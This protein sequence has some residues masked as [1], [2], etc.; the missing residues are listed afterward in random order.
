VTVIP[1]S[2]D[3][4]SVEED[5]LKEVITSYL[6]IDDVLQAH[7]LSTVVFTGP[8]NI[9]I[10]AGANK[11]L[12]SVGT[13]KIDVIDA[14]KSALFPPQEPYLPLTNVSSRYRV[15]TSHRVLLTSFV[16][17]SGK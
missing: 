15:F 17:G 14:I 7:F 9:N 6:K 8:S 16:P 11:V 3:C 13:T 10:T 1:L 5:W 4:N 12:Q 2:S